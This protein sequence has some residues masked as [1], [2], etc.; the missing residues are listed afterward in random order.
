MQNLNFSFAATPNRNYRQEIERD[1][2]EFII[3]EEE[4]SEIRASEQNSVDNENQEEFE[5]I[6]N[7]NVDDVHYFDG[8]QKGCQDYEEL[9]HERP[10]EIKDITFPDDSKLPL[11]V[12]IDYEFDYAT[13]ETDVTQSSF[14]EFQ[15]INCF[16]QEDNN[17]NLESVLENFEGF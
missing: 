1:Q 3:D 4:F 12:G 17:Y 5:K 10:A 2:D 16:F 8:N 6:N 15:N 13:R 7:K 9:L 11:G 14:A